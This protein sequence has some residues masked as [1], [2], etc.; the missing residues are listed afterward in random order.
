MSLAN[1]LASLEAH[2]EPVDIL[3]ESDAFRRAEEVAIDLESIR[4]ELLENDGV[5]RQLAAAMESIQAG[6]IPEQYPMASFTKAYSKTNYK[7]SVEVIDVALATAL[8]VFVGAML[9]ILAKM[10]KWMYNA[11][12]SSTKSAQKAEVAGKNVTTLAEESRKLEQ[13]MS[14]DDLSRAGAKTKSSIDLANSELDGMHSDLMRDLLSNGEI[15]RT[16]ITVGTRIDNYLSAVNE[17]I[18]AFETLS[19]KAAGPQ[20]DSSSVS[21]LAQT[22]ALI[23]EIPAAP[24]VGSA[25]DSLVGAKTGQNISSSLTALHDFVA[26]AKESRSTPPFKYQT[27]IEMVRGGRIKL[28][29]TYLP[30]PEKTLANLERLEKNIDRASKKLDKRPVEAELAKSIRSAGNVIKREV[31]AIRQFIGLINLS[32]GTVNKA[33]STTFKTATAVYQILVAEAAASAQE[34]IQDQARRSREG[35]RDKLERG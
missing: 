27:L 5:N 14:K 35:I 30:N 32:I 10:F 4:D 26:H 15:R 16:L 19:E 29:E 6:L 3:D 12:F 25:I 9:V 8:G 17:K 22:A 11:L 24:P 21:L 31:E 23:K 28:N 2:V 34:T 33:T 18:K 13:I 1:Q 20:D 7:V